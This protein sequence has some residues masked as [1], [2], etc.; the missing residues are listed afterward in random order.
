MSLPHVAPGDTTAALWPP[1]GRR[2][3]LD[4][5]RILAICGV[6]AIHTFGHTVTNESMRGS[7]QWVL[8]VAL[9]FGFV[10]TVP[11][12]VMISGALALL[13][14]VHRDGPAAFYRK[15]AIR[16]IPALV[17]WHL[18]YLVLVRILLRG[19]EISVGYLARLLIDGQVYTQLYFLWLILGLYLVAPV[20]AAF[21]NA[22]TEKRARVF[23][24]VA[25]VWTLLVFMTPGIMTLIGAPRPISLGALTMWWPYVGYFVAGYALSRTRFSGRQAIIAGAAAVVLAA[26]AIWQYAN[27]ADLPVLQAFNPVGYLGAGVA[28][29]A[30]CVFIAVITGVDRVRFSD[31]TGRVVV[32][33]SDAS[34]GVFLVHMVFMALFEEF[35]PGVMAGTSVAALAGVFLIILVVSYAVSLLAA[36]IPGVR[37]VF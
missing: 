19:E 21:L 34:F 32:A 3:S 9:D 5:L 26:L 4:V 20:L 12:F 30:I 35:L 33:L 23:A 15:R 31:R 29:L 16:I 22:G 8:A 10:W 28:L 36:R 6:V 17:V 11:V 24:A 18:V 37:L 7:K 27:R 14:R 1:A 2:H 25:L 13:P